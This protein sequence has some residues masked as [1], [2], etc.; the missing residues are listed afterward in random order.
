MR[1]GIAPPGART[2]ACVAG[3]AKKSNWLAARA[4]YRQKL[5]I[6][7]NAGSIGH[8]VGAKVAHRF[9]A[10][11]ARHIRFDLGIDQPAQC[12]AHVMPVDPARR[13]VEQAPERAVVVAIDSLV[14]NI[15]NHG[16]L[17]LVGK[18]QLRVRAREQRLHFFRPFACLDNLILQHR[19]PGAAAGRG[20]FRARRPG[21]H[22]NQAG[23]QYPGEK[24][25]PGKIEQRKVD[26]HHQHRCRGDH[27]DNRNEGLD[28]P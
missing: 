16:R 14:V 18:L 11:G 21:H 22:G 4:Q 8:F 6:E 2:F 9:A 13:K 7:A 3:D 26:R 1:K 17:L 23:K 27:G 10:E 20:K 15:G 12:L 28:R 24:G 25:D 19:E 5:H